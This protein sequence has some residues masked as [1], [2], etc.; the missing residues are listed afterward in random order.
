MKLLLFDFDGTIVDSLRVAFK[1]YNS[2]AKSYGIKEFKNEKD[3]SRLYDKNIYESFIEQG[4]PRERINDFMIDLRNAFFDKGYSALLFPGIKEAIESLATKN[5]VIIITSNLSP[6]VRKLL[7]DAG[8]SGISD[9]LGG[10]QGRSKVE[11]IKNVMNRYPE[12]DI[13]YIGDTVGD[14]LEGKKAGVKTVAVTWGYHGKA[15][16]KRA[17]PDYIADRA[18]ELVKILN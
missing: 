18:E 1:A 15:K 2:I 9:V 14:V 11:K 5:K 3:F 12:V 10:D 13:Y 4:V 17:K 7:S 6:A 8:L 16:L